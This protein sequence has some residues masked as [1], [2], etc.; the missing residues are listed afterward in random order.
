[1]NPYAN[2]IFYTSTY[3]GDI[4]PESK[5]LRVAMKASQYVRT[6][7][8]DQADPSD[9]LIRC[10]TCEVADMIYGN[11]MALKNGREIASENTDGYSVSYAVPEG[12]A[13]DTEQKRAGEIIRIYLS[14]TKY[15]YRG[16]DGNDYE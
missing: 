6:F 12:T 13:E 14:G 15:L 9:N 8:F 3:G 5:W 16:I 11:M 7:T 2:Y 4:V 10:A 1:M